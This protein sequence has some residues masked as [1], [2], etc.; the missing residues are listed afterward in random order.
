MNLNEQDIKNMQ[1]LV[2]NITKDNLK[3]VNTY[4]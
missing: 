3:C 2:G 4:G 1:N